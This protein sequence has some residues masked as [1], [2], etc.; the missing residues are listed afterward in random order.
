M[1]ALESDLCA[2][3]QMVC[4]AL[5]RA[6]VGASP[7]DLLLPATQAGQCG[8]Q[9]LRSYSR[10]LNSTE[11]CP[12]RSRSVRHT[13]NLRKHAQGARVAVL[14][15]LTLSK[16][17]PAPGRG[18]ALSW[19]RGAPRP[20]EPS[21]WTFPPSRLYARRCVAPMA[22]RRAQFTELG[23]RRPETPVPRAAS[24]RSYQGGGEE[25][26]VVVRPPQPAAV[27]GP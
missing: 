8:I 23:G 11:P 17:R 14:P 26:S 13:R 22:N 10:R 25:R 1:D 21:P 15:A 9:P 6:V 20:N 2:R 24:S 18:H 7:S 27:A 19:V 4:V 16:P 3:G 5:S 12:S